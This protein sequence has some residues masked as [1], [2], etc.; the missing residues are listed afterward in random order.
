MKVYDD[1]YTGGWKWDTDKGTREGP[2]NS[3]QEYRLHMIVYAPYPE[4]KV[5]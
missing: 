1:S 3:L 4:V 2:L 5:L